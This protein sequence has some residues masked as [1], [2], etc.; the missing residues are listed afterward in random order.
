MYKN[1]LIYFICLVLFVPLLQGCIAVAAGGAATGA[2]VAADRRTAGTIVDDKA[3]EIKVNHALS[4]DDALWK[5]S[6]F[7]VLCYNN[8]L[9]LAGQTPTEADKRHAEE[10]ISDIPKIRRV[11]NELTI[12]KP[13][14]LR[15]RSKDSWITTQIKAKLV[16]S[17]IAKA[18]RIKV[19]TENGVVYLMGMTTLE[20]ED[21]ATDIAQNIPGV[22]KVIQI[23]ERY[24]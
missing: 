15:V 14:S 12:E 4:R 8:V 16:G 21:A 2:A 24:Q 5:V 17:K 13:A 7:N 3:I 1:Q 23:F 6:H 22:E 18:T 11:H 9:L 19:L 20:E 10:L